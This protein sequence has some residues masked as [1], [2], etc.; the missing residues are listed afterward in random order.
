MIVKNQ[1][2]ALQGPETSDR[3]EPSLK[4]NEDKAVST[5]W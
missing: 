3:R 2:G 4:E 1:Q 5:T